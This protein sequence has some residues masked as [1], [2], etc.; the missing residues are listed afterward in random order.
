MLILL[1]MQVQYQNREASANT[2]TD[3]SRNQMRSHSLPVENNT[4]ISKTR[5]ADYSTPRSATVVHREGNGRSIFDIPFPEG[6][7]E[8]SFPGSRVY[9]ESSFNK[10][11]SLSKSPSWSSSSTSSPGRV[12]DV[13]PTSWRNENE[14]GR[15]VDVYPALSYSINSSPGGYVGSSLQPSSSFISGP[16]TPPRCSSSSSYVCSKTLGHICY[17]K[18]EN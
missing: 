6:P 13:P 7:E 10:L 16:S 17:M 1:L 8:P 3:I 18:H 5:Q 12:F 4:G 15:A 14:N 11:D 9:R 2:E